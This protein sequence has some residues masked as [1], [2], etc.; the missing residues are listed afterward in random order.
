MKRL[1]VGLVSGVWFWAAI[2]CLVSLGCSEA[3][4]A[5]GSGLALEVVSP[6][7]NLL[8]ISLDT[9]RA[10]RVGR[11]RGGKSITPQIDR[12]AADGVLFEQC[13]AHASSTLPSHASILTSLLPPQHGAYFSMGSRLAP[14]VVTLSEILSRA[15]YR[16]ASFNGGAQ[17]DAVWGLDRGFDQYE[18]ISR[19]RTTESVRI[20]PDHRLIRNVEKTI[21]WLQEK[22]PRPFFVFLHSFEVHHPYTPEPADV[23]ALGVEPGVGYRAGVSIDQLKAINA[24]SIPIERE[25]LEQIEDA[26]DA[27][28]IS[29][30]R[31]IGRLIAALSDMGLYEETMIVLT[32]DHGE[33]FGEHGRVGWHSHSLYDE[34]LRVPLILKF[35]GGR[36]AGTRVATQVRSIDIAPTA[37]RNVG[38]E[39][40][41]Q[42]LGK[43]LSSGAEDGWNG[44]LP[45]LSY[46][47]R[48]DPTKRW[49]L[50]TPRWKLREG[51][52]HDLARDSE[53]LVDLSFWH[54]IQKLQLMLV[55]RNLLRER[56]LSGPTSVE[57]D[58]ETK[59]Q[60][61]ALGYVTD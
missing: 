2:C 50:R 42:F 53:E 18:S 4:R 58:T 3:E 56:A 60:L 19:R 38:V 24:G 27:E 35:P 51:R 15:G 45:V 47:D 59:E 33:E 17:L 10:D 55:S 22:D 49:S 13:Y 5:Q 48:P 1:T 39:A 31:A 23:E 41:P 54:W 16:T 57:P 11:E 36:F 8:L 32:S 14:D 44:D 30:D 29:A 6:P 25:G 28:V 34:L 26:Y 37:L 40:P 20:A 21:N 9:F 43:D 61:R 7:K 12:L 52:L 46:R